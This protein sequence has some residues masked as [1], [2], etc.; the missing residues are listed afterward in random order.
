M[1]EN[2]NTAVSWIPCAAPLPRS[3]QASH[4]ETSRPTTVP[5]PSTTPFACTRARA[6]RSVCPRPPASRQRS[7][8]TAPVSPTRPVEGGSANAHDYCSG[9]PINCTDLLGLKEKR[10]L[11]PALRDP[12]YNK[13]PGT[14]AQRRAVFDLDI[15]THYRLATSNKENSIFYEFV[16]DGRWWNQPDRPSPVF[17]WVENNFAVIGGAAFGCANNLVQVHNFGWAA[18]AA[19]KVPFGAAV[20][21]GAACGV[22]IVEGTTLTGG[23][24]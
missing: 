24:P 11:P 19:T 7:I 2:G 9:D 18:H 13:G 8:E 1:T 15:C 20:V 16:E 3:S 4:D 12:C 14:Q 10:D 6:G 5:D 21:Y 17:Q 22:G 23:F